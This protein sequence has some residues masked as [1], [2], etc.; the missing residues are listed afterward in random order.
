[1]HRF[2]RGALLLFVTQQLLQLGSDVPYA[3]QNKCCNHSAPARSATRSTRR[4]TACRPARAP[5]ALSHL[6][7]LDDAG[8]ACTRAH[9]RLMASARAGGASCAQKQAASC[10]HGSSKGGVWE[11]T[12]RE[13]GHVAM[14][15]GC[16]SLC[17]R[18]GAAPILWR[19]T[20]LSPLEQSFCAFACS[21]EDC[22]RSRA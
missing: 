22:R 18:I 9:V 3:V 8:V 5:A 17:E 2:C 16:G 19:A 7:N 11:Q 6:H 4:L 1:M 14:L 12:A 20:M 15:R 10:P 13:P 21:T